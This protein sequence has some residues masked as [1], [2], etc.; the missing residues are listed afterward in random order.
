MS[1][2]DG[3]DF[4]AGFVVGALASA[5]LALLFAPQTGKQT[6]Q[7][8]KEQSFELKGRAREMSSKARE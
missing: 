6:R 4:L 2:N 7:K 5:A 1:D 3:A 8:I